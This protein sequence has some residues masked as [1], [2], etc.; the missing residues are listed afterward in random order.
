V[1]YTLHSDDRE[2]QVIDYIAGMTDQYALR[3]AEKLEI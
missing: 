1:E 2:R 3:L